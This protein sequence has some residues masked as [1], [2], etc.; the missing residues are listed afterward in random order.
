MTCLINTQDKVD[1][2]QK[3]KILTELKSYDKTLLL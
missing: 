1:C 2:R 3:I